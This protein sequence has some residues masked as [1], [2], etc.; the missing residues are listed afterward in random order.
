[1]T[2]TFHTSS[3]DD[4]YAVTYVFTAFYSLTFKNLRFSI[5]L[6]PLLSDNE[7]PV[8]GLCST[9]IYDVQN[10]DT[11]K[12]TR[13]ELRIGVDDGMRNLAPTS[14]VRPATKNMVA[15]KKRL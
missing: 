15:E 12:S 5:G 10:F 7:Q 4:E 14:Y 11:V 13:A 1:M 6:M 2:A 3:E 8:T 9:Y